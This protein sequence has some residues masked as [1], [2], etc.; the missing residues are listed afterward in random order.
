M[1]RVRTEAIAAWAASGAMWLTGDEGGPPL[2]PAAPIAVRMAA[3]GKQI[4]DLAATAAPA[5]IDYP[6]LLGERA[7]I[8]GLERHGAE[9]CGRATRLIDAR[10]AKLVIGLPRPVDRASIPAW[11]GVEPGPDSQTD[12]DR[13]ASP[14]AAWDAV[15]AA[16]AQMAA[17]D[18]VEQ[19]RLLEIPC[20]R[21]GEWTTAEWAVERVGADGRRPSGR[22]PS[23]LDLSTLWAGP[24]CGTLLGLAG[25]DVTKAEDPRRPDGARSGPEA[26]FRLLNGAKRH[27]PLDVGSRALLTRLAL[28]D[29]V[30]TSGRPRA[31]EALGI[32][33]REVL[34]ASPTVWIAVTAY[35]WDGP[36]RD[37][38]GFGDDAAAAAGLLAGDCFAGDAI[39]DPLCGVRAAAVALACLAEGGSW[40]VDAALAGA[41]RDAFEPGPA[42]AAHAGA[43]G[44]VVSAGGGEYPVSPPRA[45][46]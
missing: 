20:A 11:L 43:D 3:L 25:A 21:V 45:R 46:S 44:W 34:A 23:V 27:A 15:E 35:G 7:A 36:G 31:F 38:V 30:I 29:V 6:A 22:R 42:T 28:A 18:V 40:F 37:R 10:D 13:H 33:P 41:A 5:D 14:L 32:D 19:A 9:S 24:L 8:T 39:A 26:F 17:A 16:V 12:P 2:A 4:A 1:D